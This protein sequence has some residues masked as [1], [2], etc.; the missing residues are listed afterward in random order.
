MQN[1]DH[2]LEAAFV[3]P[4]LAVAKDGDPPLTGCRF[5]GSSDLTEWSASPAREV[6]TRLISSSRFGNPN[7]GDVFFANERSI[8]IFS[9]HAS[10]AQSE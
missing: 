2:P 8:N 5:R 10:P 9:P 7:R 1:G 6:V 4:G 3:N